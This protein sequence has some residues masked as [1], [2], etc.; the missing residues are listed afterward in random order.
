MHPSSNCTLPPISDLFSL[1]RRSSNSSSSH[2]TVNNTATSD[3]NTGHISVS[4]IDTTDSYHY[5][6][7]EQRGSSNKASNHYPP[8]KAKRKRASPSQLTVLNQV[9]NQTYFPST[10]LR[11]ELGK[12]LGMSPRTVQIWFQNKRQSLR[13]RTQ[14]YSFSSMEGGEEQ[15]NE[16][17]TATYYTQRYQYD[18]MGC[19]LSSPPCTPTSVTSPAGNDNQHFILPPP[20]GSSSPVSS[21]SST[22]MNEYDNY[23]Q[24]Q[25]HNQK[26]NLPPLKL[27]QGP[28]N[29]PSP[30]TS[31]YPSPISIDSILH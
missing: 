3:V 13:S 6:Y 28:Y 16:S 22:V 25:H 1:P 15:E 11:V 5:D 27:Y 19:P 17:T 18:M 29:P 12:H 21:T 31:T 20:S 8:L 2:V 4:G 24:P 10:E 14:R 23:F 30:P 7:S 9:F 26:V